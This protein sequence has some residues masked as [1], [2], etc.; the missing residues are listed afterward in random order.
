MARMVAAWLAVDAARANEQFD[1]AIALARF[2]SL[3]SRGATELP[4]AGAYAPDRMADLAAQTERW[5]ATWDD[6]EQ[7]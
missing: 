6:R 7:P 1:K 5:L 3:R 2:A 4:I